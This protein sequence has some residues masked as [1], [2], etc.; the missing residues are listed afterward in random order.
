S[1]KQWKIGVRP[2]FPSQTVNSGVMLNPGESWQ[3]PASHIE[4]FSA[5]TLEGRLL[6][7]G[8]PP[9]NLARYISELKAYPYG[10]LEQTTSGL[11]PSLYTSAAQLKALG[12]TG[13][14]DKQRRAAI[15]LG[16]SRLLE[17][18]REDGGFSLW[19]K[20]GPEEYWGTA[21][22]TDFLVRA[23]EQGYSVPADALE[24]ANNRLLRYL[25]DPGLMA[26][27]YSDNSAA[28]KFAV[29]AYASLVLA[30]QQKAPLGAL[31]ELWNRHNAAV[32]GLP[33]VQLGVALKLMGDATRSQDA[34]NAG[35]S[36]TRNNRTEWIGDYGS[37]LRDNALILNLLEENKLLAQQQAGLLQKLSDQAFGQ[38]WLSTQESNALFLAG[39]AWQNQPAS[40]QVESSLS[41]E[42]L[43]G[44]KAQTFNLNADKLASLHLTNT[45]DSPVWVRLDSVGYPQSAPQESGNVL[46]I[47]RHF[48]AS[49]G[50]AKSLDNLRSG[51]LVMVW[52]DVYASK[53]VPDAL[54]VDLLP[55]GL[56]L[57]NQNLANASASLGES[58]GTVTDLVSRMQQQDIQHMEFRDDRF[59]A[60]LPVNAG[61][62]A[63]LVYLARAVTPGR[64]TVPVPQVE[65]M[66][67][68]AWRATGRSEGTLTIAP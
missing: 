14:S 38:N 66:Y 21:Y 56:E 15:D 13:E 65:S 61:E 29:Q 22:V 54:V 45:S 62:H 8:R 32:S 46:K 44:D 26:L 64:Y 60:A 31:R 42:P 51:E 57:E 55:A 53:T 4:G 19:D 10:C 28:S 36:T 16:I 43:Q 63:T 68:P 52:L 1:Q 67:V 3:V 47:Q 58:S 12:I 50:T 30:R 40:W 37:E 34:I 7:S 49:D 6:L 17:M 11:F 41:G 2:A 35:I 48:L 9:L 23:T 20:T 25:Q 24:R 18:Q 39:R 5:D 33:L 27:R 59:V